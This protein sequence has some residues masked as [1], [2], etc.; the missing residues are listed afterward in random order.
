MKAEL[1]I[2]TRIRVEQ[3]VFV[4]R[5]LGREVA[6][7]VGLWLVELVEPAP[8]D[9]Q[10][11]DLGLARARGHLADVARPVLGK[12]AAGYRTGG[13]EAHEVVLVARLAHVV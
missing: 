5:Q 2:R 1:L 3:D 11:Q 12:H 6:R 7:E 9:Q 8:G 4:A 13:V 10:R